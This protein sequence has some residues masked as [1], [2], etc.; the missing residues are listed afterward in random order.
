MGV[1]NSLGTLEKY[2][3]LVPT[4]EETTLQSSNAN[5]DD[6]ESDSLGIEQDKI[7]NVIKSWICDV[8]KEAFVYHKDLKSHKRIEH[9]Y[10]KSDKVQVLDGLCPHC[11]EYYKMLQQHIMYKHETNKPWKCEYCDYAHAT[12][13]EYSAKN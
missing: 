7:Q 6:N 10:V 4:K 3:L 12:R 9:N 11:G 2:L 13:C 8:C 1:G 5:G